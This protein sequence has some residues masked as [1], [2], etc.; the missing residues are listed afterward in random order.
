MEFNLLFQLTNTLIVLLLLG[1]AGYGYA[2]FVK[3]ARLYI[4]LAELQL[5][6]R[7]GNGKL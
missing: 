2:L 6:E 1:A 5:E 3:A 4:H 7:K